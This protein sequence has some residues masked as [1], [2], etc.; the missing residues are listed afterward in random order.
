MDPLLWHPIGFL[1]RHF[2]LLFDAFEEKP[3]RF[4]PQKLEWDSTFFD[5]GIYKI[6]AFDARSLTRDQIVQFFSDSNANYVFAEVP[7]EALPQIRALQN[8]GFHLVET[9][10]HYFH[11]LLN[12][13][14]QT[15]T[16]RIASRT[17]TEA[18]KKVAVEAVNPYDRYHADPFFSTKDANRYLATYISNC[19][20]GF[21][22]CVFVPDTEAE[23]ASF[24]AL[25]LANDRLWAESKPLYRIPLTACLPE[26]KGWHFHLCLAA[27]Q[28]AKAKRA[29]CLVMTTQTTNGAVIHNCEKLG[30][31]LGHCSHI[32]SQSNR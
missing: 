23:P 25:S 7:A 21:A 8:S 2:N 6:G 18:L 5:A 12:L 4:N 31:K 27:L 1:S 26:N 20:S 13:E 32:F 10:L 17:D 22:E 28:Y 16:T 29:A 14:S 9:R 11:L 3:H 15:R 24:A 30:F 19:I